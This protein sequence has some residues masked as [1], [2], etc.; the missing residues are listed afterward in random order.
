MVAGGNTHP[1]HWPTQ[2]V[3]KY[4]K[5]TAQ[6]WGMGKTV[7][8]V[9]TGKTKLMEFAYFF[10]ILPLVRRAARTSDCCVSVFASALWV[11]I[12]RNINGRWLVFRPLI[13]LEITQSL[14][15]ASLAVTHKR[16]IIH[17][18]KTILSEITN[19]SLPTFSA[20]VTPVKAVWKLAHLEI[21]V[22]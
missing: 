1:M 21:S 19:S 11:R 14:K 3:N 20:E 6:A 18:E 13:P 10:Q 17:V 4:T 16:I 22:F 5:V 7:D 12:L 2:W 15:F 9:C 8:V